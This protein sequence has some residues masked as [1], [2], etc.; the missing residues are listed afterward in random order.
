M[1]KLVTSLLLAACAASP[2][3]AQ[4]FKALLY[5]KTDGW[6]HDSINA[7]VTAIQELSKLH[8]FEVYWTENT[9][10]VFTDQ[11]LKEYDVVIF[12]LTTGDVLDDQQQAAFERYI[13]A[14]G[15]YVGIHSAS[16]TEYGW[17]WYTK[18]VGHMFHIHPAIQ[19][20]VMKVEDPDFPGMDRFADKFLFTEEWYEFDAPRTDDL[21][22]LLSV[23]EKTYRP[24]A[25]W[26]AKKGEGMGDFHPISWYKEYDGGRAFYTALGHLP[27]T[28]SD[29]DFMHHV[30]GGIYW[31]ATGNGFK[32]AD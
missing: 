1:R 5:T 2:L 3:F 7:G 14:G 30:Y 16:D 11:K 25:N 29:A 24:A 19:T 31:A 27:A 32:S 4:Q 9:G 18:M 6:H 21:N 22:Y 10:M 17:D 13:Q 23:D 12:L 15:G 26:G 28:Y 8:H 20:G